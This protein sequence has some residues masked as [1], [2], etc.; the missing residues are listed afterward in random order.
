MRDEPLP[1]SLRTSRASWRSIGFLRAW[2]STLLICILPAASATQ[3]PVLVAPGVYALIGDIGDIT[4]QNRGVIGNA[5][6]VVG[7][8][9]V[10]V[11]DTGVSFRYGQ[12]V[13]AAIA[14]VTPLPVQLVVLTTPIQEFHFGAAAFQDRGIPVLAHRKAAALI[15]ERCAT[16]LM[17]LRATLGEEEMAGSRVIVPDRLIDDSASMT[18]AGR[19]IDL[20]YFGW[21]SAPGD[22]AVFDRASGVLFAG[23]LIS[24]DRIPRLRDGNLKGWIAALEQLE[25]IP[26]RI[27]V[28][29]HG[30]IATREQA[31]RT[32]AYLRALKAR[33]D[34]L[35]RQGVGLSKVVAAAD[36]PEFRSWSLYDTMHAENVQHWYL[37]LEKDDLRSEGKKP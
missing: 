28:P 5:E 2:L 12:Q 10:L 37:Q 22:L 27:I 7:D 25:R 24:V 16:C 34:A 6:F 11:I 35:Y 14:R 3:S 1:R 4:P 23:G 30:P 33:V 8:S 26:A 17:R 15:A 13:R 29:G 19:V 18:I 31:A 32:M 9:G 20:L 21:A 36:L